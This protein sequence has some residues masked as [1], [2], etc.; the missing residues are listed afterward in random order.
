MKTDTI[1]ITESGEGI[2]EILHAIEDAGLKEGYDSREAAHLRLL[3][4]ETLELVGSV[5]GRM[6]ADFSADIK[7]DECSIRLTTHP[8]H[9]TPERA[10]LMS[11]A[12]DQSGIANKI[13]VL[14]ESSF[15]ELLE[16]E[17]A[18]KEIGIHRVSKKMLKDMGRTGEG[19]VWT[20]DS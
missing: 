8:S 3:M 9:I 2:P 18:I 4:E 19:F 10:R 16:N 5:T 1:H 20:L 11:L 15:D 12:A 6:E 7:K 13:A 14:F 17:E